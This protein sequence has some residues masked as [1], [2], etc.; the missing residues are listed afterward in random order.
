M[1]IS[2]SR[3]TDLPAF[4]GEWFMNCL[5]EK[6]A[7][8]KNPMNAKVVSKIFLDRDSVDCFVFWTKN[9]R[10]FMK[11]L[12]ELDDL[13]FPY[14][15]QFTITPYDNDIERSLGDK[16]EI[17][18]TFIELSKR[19][20]RER[21]IWRYDPIII[22]E[23]YT[24]DFHGEK[25]REM[26]AMLSAYTEKCVISFIDAY[27]FLARAFNDHGIKELSGEQMESV[28]DNITG[29]VRNS[30]RK[31]E[32]ASCCEKE[33]LGKFGVSRNRC[34]DSELINRVFDLKLGYKKDPGQRLECGCAVSRDIGAYNTC[35]HGCVYCYAGRGIGKS[36]VVDKQP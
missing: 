34:I 18:N 26:Y 29:T 35:G 2:A 15:F 21:V 12:D 27:S 8:V 4:H 23:K 1:I 3:R 31:L 17:I 16:G 5:R 28:M 13:G 10:N 19:I 9:P 25:Y 33:D 32:L 14:Y 22:N 11:Y 20:G 7:M 36:S 6:Y 24:V 30:E